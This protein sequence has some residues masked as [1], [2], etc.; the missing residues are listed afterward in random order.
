[1]TIPHPQDEASQ[2]PVTYDQA[3][4]R[5]GPGTHAARERH[6]ELS[7]R[8]HL[9]RAYA[10]LKASASTTRRSTAPGTPSR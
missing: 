9:S 5:Y 6:D 10:R 3:S 7:M 8:E 1:M 4:H 2:P